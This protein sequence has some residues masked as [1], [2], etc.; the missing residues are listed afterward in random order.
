MKVVFSVE[1]HKEKAIKELKEK[2]QSIVSS[3]KYSFMDSSFEKEYLTSM[4]EYLCDLAKDP[5]IT[6]E[7]NKTGIPDEI[8]LQ[9]AKQ[10]GINVSDINAFSEVMLSKIQKN[11]TLEMIFDFKLRESVKCYKF[12]ISFSNS[13][14]KEV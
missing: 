10:K 13:N 5:T 14:A 3:T 11:K 12:D 6:K 1:N 2:I 4:M 8:V 9:F 7:I